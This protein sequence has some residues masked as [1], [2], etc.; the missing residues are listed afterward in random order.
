MFPVYKNCR[1]SIV[2]T[3]LEN[4]IYHSNSIKE[5]NILKQVHQIAYIILEHNE[6]NIQILYS[7]GGNS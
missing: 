6:G 7:K 4:R 1:H 5:K 3:I 2:C